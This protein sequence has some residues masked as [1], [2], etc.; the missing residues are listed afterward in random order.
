M[1]PFL[2]DI[3][4]IYTGDYSSF[5]VTNLGDIKAWGLN[6]NNLLLTDQ[7]ERGV[8]KNIVTEPMVMQLPD[9]FVRSSTTKIL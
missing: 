6:K 3:T 4:Q 5:A 8:I 2:R 9:Y 1:I 7:S